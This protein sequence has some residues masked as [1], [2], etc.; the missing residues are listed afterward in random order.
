[1]DYAVTEMGCFDDYLDGPPRAKI[2]RGN[3]ITTFI[4]QVSQCITFRQ[5]NIDTATIIVKASLKSFYSSLGFKVIK[6]IARS[7][8]FLEACKQFNYV[9]GKSKASKKTPLA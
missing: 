8:N 4:F 1:M 3:G 9:S 5:T 2:M 7:P 6:K